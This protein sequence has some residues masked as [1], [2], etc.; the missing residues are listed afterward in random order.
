MDSTAV[1][2]YYR[3]T[4][5]G[6]LKLSTASEGVRSIDFVSGP[7]KV[8]GSAKNPI[9]SALI[10]ELDLYFRGALNLFSVPLDP[11][12]GTPFQR[13]VWRELTRIPY[14]ET[15]SYGKIAAAVGNPLGARAVGLA[16]KRNCIPIVI[17]CHRVIKADGGLGGYD[18]GLDIK[19]ALLHLEGVRI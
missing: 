11:E 6:W 4:L 7:L 12:K 19:R 17:P 9:M 3:S 10:H 2:Q 8:D 16:N 13:K 15:R 5:V 18:S 1:V 14:G